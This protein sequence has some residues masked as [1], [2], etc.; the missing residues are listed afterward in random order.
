MSKNSNPVKIFVTYGEAIELKNA[1]IFKKSFSQLPKDTDP[2]SI[3]KPLKA[4]RKWLSGIMKENHFADFAVTSCV[5]SEIIK[6]SLENRTSP[7]F[8][9]LEDLGRHADG[10]I[11]RLKNDFNQ[12]LKNG[13]IEK[14]ITR[15]CLPTPIFYPK[16]K[17]RHQSVFF[18]I[19][20]IYSTII[21]GYKILKNEA[22]KD[23]DICYIVAL[24]EFGRQDN[25]RLSAEWTD[26]IKTRFPKLDFYMSNNP[27]PKT[28][29]SIRK[30]VLS[31]QSVSEITKESSDN[32]N[33]IWAVDHLWKSLKHYNPKK[34][35]PLKNWLATG[36]KFN[37]ENR[38]KKADPIFLLRRYNFEDL[39]KNGMANDENI[40]DFQ[41]DQSDIQKDAKKEF[42][43]LNKNKTLTFEDCLDK[44]KMT[45]LRKIKEIDLASWFKINPKT[46][47]RR[48]KK[49]K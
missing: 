8:K 27:L 12:W 28:G 15:F 26:L 19:D 46:I 2:Y 21:E 1:G 4:N 10:E 14:I 34:K 22:I 24:L 43:S 23:S 39:G 11:E 41:I 9:S 45:G 5:V 17:I 29:K 44:V 38:Y 33:Y 48:R 16:S 35:R 6:P 20:Y 37:L 31:D 3:G 49:S 40:I 7:N 30:A 36:I 32:D 47:Q 13:E 42:E 18:W 25:Q